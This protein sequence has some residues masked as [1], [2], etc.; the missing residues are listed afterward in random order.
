[1]TS[2]IKTE[3]ISVRDFLRNF[4]SLVAGTSFKQYVIMKHGKPIGVFTPWEA[5]KTEMKKGYPGSFLDWLKANQFSGGPDLTQ[6]IDE[7]VY[8][9]GRDSVPD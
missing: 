3:P 7:I 6:R 2:K 1:M 8:G 9:I 5:Q 4:A